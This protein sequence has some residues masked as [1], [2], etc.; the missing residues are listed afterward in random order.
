MRICARV[1]KLGINGDPI[2]ARRNRVVDCW[3]VGI[4]RTVIVLVREYLA[5]EYDRSALNKNFLQEGR[6]IRTYKVP[7]PISS[8]NKMSSVSTPQV[9]SIADPRSASVG[10]YLGRTGNGTGLYSMRCP[11]RCPGFLSADTFPIASYDCNCI[12]QHRG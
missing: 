4:R 12:C 6:I 2:Q 5:V 7:N 8:M 3:H 1:G 9:P 11:K 10:S